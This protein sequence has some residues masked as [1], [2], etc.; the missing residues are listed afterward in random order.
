MPAPTVT[1]I[2]PSTGAG[3]GGTFVTITGSSMT[4]ATSASV[5][6][7]NLTS[8]LVLSDTTVTGI[9]GIHSAGA[10]AV[11]VTNPTGTGTLAAAFTYGN[12]TATSVF[13]LYQ[14]VK[15]WLKL[16]NDS[17]QS[18]ITSL[19][20]PA[21]DSIKAY[22]SRDILAADY[23]EKLNGT[24]QKRM[25][26]KNSPII[27]VTSLT[28]GGLSI[29]A[30]ANSET[31]GFMYDNDTLYLNEVYLLTGVQSM[32]YDNVFEKGFQNVVVSYRAGYTTV[33]Q[34]IYQAAVE[35]VSLRF[36]DRDRIGE[37]S[38][39]VGGQEVAKYSHEYMPSPIKSMLDPYRRK[40]I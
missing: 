29:T 30:A 22:L 10:V 14:D 19:L 3:L 11:A 23:V 16:Q 20:Q 21:T 36:K 24:G 9:T 31:A 27:S 8:L 26:L 35:L 25:F 40:N 28:I 18:L 4:G 12:P 2:V 15:S 7:V 6:G 37:N 33:P 13:C 5:G 34:P 32:G 1:S 17:S 39:T 38:K